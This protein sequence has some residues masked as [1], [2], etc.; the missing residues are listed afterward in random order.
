MAPAVGPPAAT[1]GPTPEGGGVRR[2][3]SN[4]NAAARAATMMTAI[5]ANTHQGM[6]VFPAHWPYSQLLCAGIAPVAGERPAAT[7]TA[8]MATPSA[9]GTMREARAFNTM[10]GGALRAP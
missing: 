10:N 8:T 3:R 7:M 2:R 5:A 6:D 4:S 1:A 9:M